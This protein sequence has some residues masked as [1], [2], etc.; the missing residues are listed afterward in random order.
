MKPIQRPRGFTLVEAMVVVAILGVILAVAVPNFA[1]FIRKKRLEGVAKEFVADLALAR[2]EVVSTGLG[3][4]RAATFRFADDGT[5]YILF[6]AKALASTRCD[7]RRPVGD[8]CRAI[9]GA[10]LKITKPPAGSGIVYRSEPDW[11]Y[12]HYLDGYQGRQD[13][14]KVTIAYPQGPTLRVEVRKLGT[15]SICSPDGSVSGHEACRLD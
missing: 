15:A 5:C 3:N 11:P 4:N 10:E 9:P 12:L 1:D 14:Y 13:A 8:A 6:V 7:C 2:S